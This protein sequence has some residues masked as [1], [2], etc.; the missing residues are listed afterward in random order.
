MYSCISAAAVAVVH[1]VAAF[2]HHLPHNAHYCPTLFKPKLPQDPI[3]AIHRPSPILALHPTA[4]TKPPQFTRTG[5][6]TRYSRL[7]SQQQPFQP[8][9]HNSHVWRVLVVLVVL[10]QRRSQVPKFP[11]S[12]IPKFP[13]FQIEVPWGHLCTNHNSPF[14]PPPSCVESQPGGRD[15]YVPCRTIPCFPFANSITGQS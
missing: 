4:M 12:Q 14:P 13:N 2:S 6:E 3:P 5:N 1:L 8:E 10:V 15:Q 9:S 11:N 7:V